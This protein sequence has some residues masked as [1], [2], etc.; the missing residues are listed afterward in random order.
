[1]LRRFMAWLCCPACL[2]KLALAKARTE[3]DDRIL[4]GTLACDCCGSSYPI[5]RGVP[6]FVPFQNYAEGF[7]FQWKTHALTQY[8][9]TSG[10]EAS[11]KRFLEEAKW[12]L[13]LDGERILEVGCGAGRFSV[14]ALATGAE[15]ASIDYSAAVDVNYH[16]GRGGRVLFVAQVLAPG[17]CARCRR[18]REKPPKLLLESKVLGATL[19]PPSVP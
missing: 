4:N 3:E 10:V 5:I 14:H 18:L 11:R 15:V 12:P 17:R 19:E 6:R 2:G 8:D 9:S 1:M 13:R 7:G 16:T